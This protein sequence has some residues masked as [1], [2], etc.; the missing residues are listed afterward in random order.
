MPCRSI[1]A[2][3]PPKSLRCSKTFDHRNQVCLGG[4]R[5]W[6]GYLEFYVNLGLFSVNLYL[7]VAREA[8]DPFLESI[9]NFLRGVAFISNR[10]LHDVVRV[11]NA[12]RRFV[13]VSHRIDEIEWVIVAVAEQIVIASV[14]AFRVFTHEAAD[15]GMIG[16][17]AG[18]V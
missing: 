11:I 4:L 5:L 8:F 18:F 12:L 16:A 13:V 2:L 7:V 1:S 14:V 3:F 15:A 10:N 9:L 17:G 6:S